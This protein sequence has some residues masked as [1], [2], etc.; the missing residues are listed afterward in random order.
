MNKKVFLSVIIPVYN[1]AYR[2]KKLREVY[3]FL[4]KQ[5]YS[6]EIIVVNDGSTDATAKRLA[7][8]RKTFPFRV[9]SYAKNRGKGYALIQGMLA[10]RGQYR[11]FTD[12]DL[13]T[14]I[15]T[16]PK[17]IRVCHKADILIGSRKTQGAILIR[18]QPMLREY[19]GKAFT[20][21]SRVTTGVPVSDFTCGFKCFSADC[22][23]VI[24]SNM[25][26]WRWGFDAESLCIAKQLGYT[27]QEVPVSWENNPN[28]R[29]KIP[30]DIIR[31]FVELLRIR[32]LLMRHVYTQ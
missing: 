3:L 32:W 9:I 20:W 2:I 19:M 29:V 22:A 26:I 14:P 5:R 12:I 31:S 13:S 25:T 6:F 17:F 11:L 27:I 1:E 28:S 16:I 21:L 10:A 4:K 15:N 8:F 7:E 30:G 18:H 24:F 23:Q